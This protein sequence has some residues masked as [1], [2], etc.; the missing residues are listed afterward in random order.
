MNSERRVLLRTLRSLFL[1]DEKLVVT[2]Y[3]SLVNSWIQMDTLALGCCFPTT[4]V[5]WGL[6]PI[7]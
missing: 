1:L 2:V 6:A 3:H 5:A 4:K 7:S